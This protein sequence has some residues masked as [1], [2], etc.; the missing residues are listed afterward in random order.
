MNLMEQ[1]SFSQYGMFA[2]NLE[3]LS[4]LDF[5]RM[6]PLIRSEYVTALNPS[7]RART[8]GQI[9][10]FL[11]L[12]DI[13]ERNLCLFHEHIERCSLASLALSSRPNNYLNEEGR[14]VQSLATVVTETSHLRCLST[15]CCIATKVPTLP[16][17]YR[18]WRHLCSNRSYPTLSDIIVRQM[19]TCF[20]NCVHESLPSHS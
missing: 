12:A 5:H 11:S 9:S 19:K 14:I 18:N 8:P 13:N 7:D 3:Q 20:R 6:C 16:L 4:K 15:A 10:P 17:V 2:N 1:K